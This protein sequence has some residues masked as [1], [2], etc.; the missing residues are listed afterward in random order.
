MATFATGHIGKPSHQMQ[1][2]KLCNSGLDWNILVVFE[3]K[4]TTGMGLV[5]TVQKPVVWQLL[6]PD[7]LAIQYLKYMRWKLPTHVTLHWIEISWWF[8]KI[9]QL[10]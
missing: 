8:L 10:H 1:T 7:M 6:L 3:D 2:C 9:N 5:I 4:S